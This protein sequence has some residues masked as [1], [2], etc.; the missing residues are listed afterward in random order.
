MADDKHPDAARAIELA[1]AFGHD[2]RRFVDRRFHE[3]WANDD[4]FKTAIGREVLDG[5]FASF[6]ELETAPTTA[7]SALETAAK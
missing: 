7:S 2:A 1:D 4:D 5:A 6:T 3:L